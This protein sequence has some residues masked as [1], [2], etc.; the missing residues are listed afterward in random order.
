MSLNSKFFYKE[1]ENGITI[2]GYKFCNGG[3]SWNYYYSILSHI[4]IPNIIDGKIVN[5]IGNSAFSG[6]KWLSN[7]TIPNG[8]ITIEQY[9]F[10]NCSSLCYIDI[11]NSVTY[12]DN[13]SFNGCTRLKKINLSQ[14]LTFIGKHT[15]SNCSAINQIIIPKSVIEIGNLAFFNCKNLKKI[16]FKNRKNL[17]NIKIAENWKDNCNAE[18]IFEP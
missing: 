3:I 4:D 1:N 17:D 7:V 5:S 9:A 16:I 8:V 6:L 11:P 15:F 18:I 2:T 13:C 10:Y 14:S 12:I